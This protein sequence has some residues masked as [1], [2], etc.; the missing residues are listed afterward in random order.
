FEPW[1]EAIA[2]ACAGN[3]PLDCAA[4]LFLVGVRSGCWGG[5]VEAVFPLERRALCSGRRSLG[6]NA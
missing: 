4:E 2:P 1:I 6:P 3:H 5:K